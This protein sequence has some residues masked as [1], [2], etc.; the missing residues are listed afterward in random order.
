MSQPDSQLVFEQ[1]KLPAAQLRVQSLIGVESLSRPFRFEIELVA[2][3]EPGKS[4][5]G[6]NF[7]L[8][9]LLYDEA[10]VGISSTQDMG[11][12][13]KAKRTRWF[14]GVITSVTT[15]DEQKVGWDVVRLT[16]EPK[17]T[18]L[19]SENWRSRVFLDQSVVGLTRVALKAAFP[20]VKEDVD[21]RFEDALAKRHQETGAPA[22]TRE[23]QPEREYVVQYEESDFAFVQRW[24]EH[25]GIYYYFE[26][27]DERERLVFG[28]SSGGYS[29]LRKSF[30]YRARGSADDRADRGEVVRKLS[31][32]LRRLPQRVV[33]HDYNWR[34]PSKQ[35]LTSFADVLKRGH[36]TQREYNDHFKT[37]AQGEALAKVR[38]QELSCREDIYEGES[39][40][41]DFRPGHTFDLTEHPQGRYNQTYLLVEVRH[42]AEQPQTGTGGAGEVQYSNSFQAIPAAA[43]YRPA[44]DTPWPSI[45]GVM[46][47]FVDSSESDA[48]YADID[49]HGRYRVRLP[50][51]EAFS[52]HK[53]GQGSRFMR[54]A[55]PFVAAPGEERPA[56]GFHFPLRKGTEVVLGHVDGD[57]DRPVILAAVPNPD[58]QSPVTS[59]NRHESAI[60]TP[61]GNQIV[62]DDRQGDEGI[63]IRS[64]SG[65][66]FINYRSVGRTS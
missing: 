24:L 4:A 49:D 10:R 47:A 17:L 8:R 46:N 32:S 55:Q 23:T 5:L 48:I 51:D 29:S 44:R 30:P 31:R 2:P 6:A 43:T 63:K 3:V 1:D 62:I 54:M 18:T 12:G 35:Q 19:L 52:E 27:K 34:T 50:F 25:E 21:L 56:S 57:P 11:G 60:S 20:Q 66:V 64:S 40:V 58:F 59:D 33:L 9:D 36:G 16:L 26:H 28:D 65:S 22:R 39:Q 13:A 7:D 53:D 41:A 61:A 37:K 38:S 14:G 42:H 15:A 45:Q